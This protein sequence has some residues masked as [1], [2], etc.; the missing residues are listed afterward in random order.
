L[1][2]LP[3]KEVRRRVKEGDGMN[4]P[5]VVM[6]RREQRWMGIPAHRILDRLTSSVRCSGGAYRVRGMKRG[7][8]ASTD[9]EGARP[10]AVGSGRIGREEKKSWLGTS[11]AIQKRHAWGDR[12]R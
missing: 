12:D 8:D 4:Q 7:G 10:A 6:E 1:P 5:R 9:G 3:E 2:L 11:G